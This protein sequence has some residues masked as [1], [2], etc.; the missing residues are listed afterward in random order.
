MKS[1]VVN[2][3]SML[4]RF[5]PMQQV[6]ARELLSMIH[7]MV[8][9]NLSLDGAQTLTMVLQRETRDTLTWI[10]DVEEHGW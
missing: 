3:R 8:P 4:V 2:N 9:R 10:R 7:N 5:S 1:M 6:I